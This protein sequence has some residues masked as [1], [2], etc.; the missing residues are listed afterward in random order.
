M[1]WCVSSSMILL[2][3]GRCPKSLNT[4]PHPSSPQYVPAI[5]FSEEP[6]QSM[7]PPTC[8]TVGVVYSSFFFPPT[9][10]LEF[11]PKGFIL[12]S[13]NH[14]SFSSGHWH[15][16]DGPEDVLVTNGNLSHYA[17]NSLFRFI[18]SLMSSEC[19]RH[20]TNHNGPPVFFPSPWSVH[21]ITVMWCWCVLLLS[22]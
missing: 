18:L 8:F 13:S 7:L 12:V 16:W 5:V 4:R 3:K 2:K 10:W 11:T 17:P 19:M 20:F 21:L 15:I 9:R 6:P 14:M 1:P 22:N